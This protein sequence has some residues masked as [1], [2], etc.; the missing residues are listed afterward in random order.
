MQREKSNDPY[1]KEA[2]T[3]RGRQPSFGQKGGRPLGGKQFQQ[4]HTQMNVNTQLFGQPKS[5][6]VSNNNLCK[7]IRNPKRLSTN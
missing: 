3:D 2:E 7:E 5:P 1:K 4:N 6:S